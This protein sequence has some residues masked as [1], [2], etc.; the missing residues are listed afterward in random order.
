MQVKPSMQPIV[1]SLPLCHFDD[2]ES[3]KASRRQLKTAIFN[4]LFDMNV[5]AVCAVNQV[6]LVHTSVLSDGYCS[7]I[8]ELLH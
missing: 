7:K 2:T 3:A 4:V 6:S 5:P 8:S 1:V